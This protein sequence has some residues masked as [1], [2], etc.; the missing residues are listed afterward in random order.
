MVH[1]EQVD[2]MTD[3]LPRGMHL[4]M[5][6]NVIIYFERV[7]QDRLFHDFHESLLPGGFLVMGK[8]ESLFG[9][10]SKL[11]EPVASRERIFC[12]S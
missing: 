1:F 6:R 4:L 5:C 10:A 9:D 12:K 7:I 11:F 2:L 3:E 8:V